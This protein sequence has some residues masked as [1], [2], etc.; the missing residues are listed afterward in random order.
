MFAATQYGGLFFTHDKASILDSSGQNYTDVVYANCVANVAEQSPQSDPYLDSSECLNYRGIGYI[1]RYNYTALHAAPLYQSL[2]DEA[3]IREFKNS[4]DFKIK[5]TIHPLPLTKSESSLGDAEDGFTAW[6]LIILSFPFITGSF[7][8]FVVAERLSKAKHLQTVA[9]VK[10]SSYWISTWLW[11][12]ANYQI[13][14][15][16]TVGLMF[17]F[18]IKVL[19]T[20]DRG[21][22]GGVITLLFFFGPAAASFT[23]CVTF[24]FTSPSICNLVIII[25]GFLIGFGGSLAAFILRLI[26]SDTGNPN[27]SLIT[28]ADIVEW[29]LRFIPQF[30]L[31]KGMYNAINI[32]TFEFLAGKDITVWDSSVLQWEVIFMAWQSIVYLLLAM[33]IDEW[34]SNPRAVSRWQA[35]IKIVTF[36]FLCSGRD[37]DEV[38]VSAPDDSDVVAEHERILSGGANDDLIV[39]SQLSKIYDNGKVAVNNISFGIPPGQCFGLLGINGAGKFESMCSLCNRPS[40]FY[41]INPIPLSFKQEKLRQWAF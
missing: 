35:F 27:Q 6:F 12:V 4:D 10:P 30:S 41:H 9:G 40:K 8:T 22:V 28:A 31:A 19:T 29:V 3:I 37:S 7:A 26:G 38:T 13:P 21:V 11:D 20:T 25:S 36:Q 32:E 16:I 17:A 14:L 15:W 1:V 18:D 39:V 33:K 34:S 23:Y 5:V 2:A 24:F